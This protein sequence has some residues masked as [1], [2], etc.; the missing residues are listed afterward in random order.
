M[1]FDLKSMIKCFYKYKIL[2]NGLNIDLKSTIIQNNEDLFF[3]L[4]RLLESFYRFMLTKFLGLLKKI[5][6]NWRDRRLIINVF[7]LKIV[8]V[9]TKYGNYFVLYL[10][11]FDKV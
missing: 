9:E 6:V 5:G 7:M 4:C 10:Y 11:R 2:C 8:V 1:I 3:L